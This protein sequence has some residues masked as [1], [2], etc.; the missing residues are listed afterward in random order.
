MPKTTAKVVEPSVSIDEK[1]GTITLVLPLCT[2]DIP[3]KSG[4]TLRVASTEGGMKTGVSYKGG[5]VTA[6]VNCYR[7]NPEFRK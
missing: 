4:K 3:S 5:Q 1:A 7:P 6:S 2:E